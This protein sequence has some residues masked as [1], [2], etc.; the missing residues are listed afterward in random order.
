MMAE[1]GAYAHLR[2]WASN[3][4]RAVTGYTLEDK[5]LASLLVFGYDPDML[6]HYT[7]GVIREVTMEAIRR[8]R[9]ANANVARDFRGV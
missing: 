3:A 6:H 2:R 4:V 5:P 8:A 7:V 9:N 1:C